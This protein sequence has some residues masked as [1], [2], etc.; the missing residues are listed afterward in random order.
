MSKEYFGF[1]ST[2]EHTLRGLLGALGD[3]TVDTA[4]LAAGAVTAAKI[5]TGAVTTTKLGPDA[6]TNAK[7]ADDAVDTENIADGAIVDALVDAAAA[8]AATKIAIAAG[9]D[10]LGAGTLQAQL[11][12]IATKLDN[13][14][15][16][17]IALATKLNADAGV[18]DVNY[19]TDPQ[20]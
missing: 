8:I 16:W 10:G 17:A 5:G 14:N 2:Q 19:D 9:T 13:L 1:N 4:D 20:A 6:V 12:A 11:Q 15:D 18:T 3:G 7:I